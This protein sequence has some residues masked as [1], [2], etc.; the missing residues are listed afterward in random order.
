MEHGTYTHNITMPIIREPRTTRVVDYLAV[1]LV[2]IHKYR[3][4]YPRFVFT[5]YTFCSITF[6][7]RN[8]NLLSLSLS[9]SFYLSFARSVCIVRCSTSDYTTAAVWIFGSLELLCEIPFQVGARVLH[10]IVP[11]RKSSNRRWALET[12]LRTIFSTRVVGGTFPYYIIIFIGF[13]HPS[14]IPVAFVRRIMFFAPSL[15]IYFSPFPSRNV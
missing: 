1:I 3:Q 5:A 4:V 10:Y 6:I 7:M 11:R 9:I 12:F 2:G 8:V 15:F 13:R 14:N